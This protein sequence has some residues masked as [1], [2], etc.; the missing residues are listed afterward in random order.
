MS[1]NTGQNKAAE[2]Y[3]KRRLDFP[4]ELPREKFEFLIWT[5]FSVAQRS[6]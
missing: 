3:V 6:S 2:K 4:G 5:S 1:G